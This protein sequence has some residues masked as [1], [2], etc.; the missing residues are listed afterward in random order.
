M[1]RTK[2]MTLPRRRLALAVAVVAV[3]TATAALSPAASADDATAP[4]IVYSDT[5]LRYVA[6]FP[7]GWASNA[8]VL[9]VELSGGS[10]V[11]TAEFAPVWF[12]PDGSIGEKPWVIDPSSSTGWSIPNPCDDVIGPDWDT[13]AAFV[14]GTNY[15]DLG[16]EVPALTDEQIECGV[17]AYGWWF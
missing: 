13:W 11:C 6:V 16:I 2:R 4:T 8:C 3:F 9:A 10:G 7:A 15:P 14:D 5:Y 17:W 12:Y 1:K